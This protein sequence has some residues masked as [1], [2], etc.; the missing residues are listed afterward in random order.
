[1]KIPKIPTISSQI[2]PLEVTEKVRLVTLA[3][4]VILTFL[5]LWAIAHLWRL[6][7]GLLWPRKDSTNYI[8][9]PLFSRRQHLN[10]QVAICLS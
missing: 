6:I 5:R 4:P 3:M 9:G 10:P 1:M 7:K 2:V 8:I